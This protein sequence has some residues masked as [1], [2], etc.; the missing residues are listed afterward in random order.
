MIAVVWDSTLTARGD[1]VLQ[2]GDAGQGPNATVTGTRG[3]ASVLLTDLSRFDQ[4][5]HVS[6]KDGAGLVNETSVAINVSRSE[7]TVYPCPDAGLEMSG[8][9]NSSAFVVE[10]FGTFRDCRGSGAKQ[11]YPEPSVVGSADASCS[12]CTCSEAS[13][14]SCPASSSASGLHLNS[15]LV[16][17]LTLF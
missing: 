5:G 1:I 17:L 6:L 12:P 3:S 2:A 16:W 7:W 8:E 9:R 11:R 15:P 4:S 10:A 13:F 14:S